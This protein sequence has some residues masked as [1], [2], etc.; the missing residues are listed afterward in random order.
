MTDK[1]T[2]TEPKSK[3]SAQS[4]EAVLLG[5]DLSKLSSPERISYYMTRCSA[6]GLDPKAQPFLYITLQGKLTLYATRSA[7][8]QIAA[9]DKISFEIVKQSTEDGM[10][11]AVV[12]AT[13]KEGRSTEDIGCVMTDGLRGADLCNAHMKAITKGKRRC[14]LSLSGLGMPSEDELDT[15][16]DAKPVPIDPAT[17]DVQAEVVEGL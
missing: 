9:R 13:T 2:M 6:A 5:G 4:L 16:R 3:L 8:D 1:V 12:R 17:L 15:M 11:T 10:R 7:T 14:V